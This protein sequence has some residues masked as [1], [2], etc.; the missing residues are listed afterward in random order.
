MYL[1]EIAMISAQI[2]ALNYIV[3]GNF[4]G[5]EI[6]NALLIGPLT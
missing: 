1:L 4:K 5:S 6:L 2:A 3:T